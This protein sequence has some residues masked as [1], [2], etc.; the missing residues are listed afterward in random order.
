[1][2]ASENKTKILIVEH[3]QDDIALLLH[4]LKKAHFNFEWE[5]AADE[6]SYVMALKNFEPELI[7]SDYTMPGF[8]GVAAFEIKQK[9]AIM[10]PFIIVSGTIG[11]EE[12]VELIKTGI[13]DY[14][15]KDKLFTV[16]PKIKRAL[17]AMREEEVIHRTKNELLHTET[18]L[19]ESKEI[20]HDE[21]K[22][23]TDKLLL[24]TASAG[25]G[26]WDWDIEKDILLWD[27]GMHRLYDINEF[28][29]GSIYK[30]WIS[31]LHP[32]DLVR[33][34][35]DIQMAITGK[36]DYD[37]EFRIVMNDLSIRYIRATGIIEKDKGGKIIRLVGL[38]WD[39]SEEKETFEKLRKANRMY[40]FISQINQTITH[41]TNQ[42][43]LFPEIC[44]IALN[45]G[46]F[47]M[48]WIG[49]IDIY[50]N[51][52]NVVNHCGISEKDVEKFINAPY[53]IGGP[54]TI[55]L[56]TGKY[57]VCNEIVNDFHLKTWREFMLQRGIN[58]IIVLPI[59]KGGK[60]IGTF[61]LYATEVHFFDEPEIKLLL[62]ATGDISFA[63]D[64]FEKEEHKKR[65]EKKIERSELRMRIAQEIAH[66]GSWEM[67]LASGVAIWSD[68][69]CRIY[70]YSIED[71][72][73]TFEEWIGF[74]HPEDLE[75]V[76]EAI[77]KAQKT[78]S[79][80]SMDHR[81]V[82]KDKSIK[83]I[84]S[85]SKF[86]YDGDVPIILTAICYD[87]TE[88]K[89]AEEKLYQSEV[90]F[91][92][93]F[94]NSPVALSVFDLRTFK[95]IKN[96]IQ[97][98]RL[99]KYS[100][101][102]LQNMGPGDISP[103]YQPNGISSEELIKEVLAKTFRGE[104]PDFEWNF[105][106][107]DGNE[108]QCETRLVLLNTAGSPLVM[109]SSID[110][111][112]KKKIERAI[113]DNE[114]RLKKAEEIA[115][116][117]HWELDFITNDLM[118]SE[119]GC[120]I[121]GR[122]L[123]ENRLP[124][125]TWSKTVHPDDLERIL[126][127]IKKSQEF[128]NDS[129]F[130]HRILLDDGT[131]KYVRSESKFELDSSGKPLGMFGI[132]HDITEMTIAQN[133]LKL[134]NEELKKTNSELD[135]LVY[136][137]SHELRSPLT[138]MMGLFSLIE[139]KEMGNE[140]DE[141]LNLVK[142]SVFK[143]D[144][145]LKEMLDYSRNTRIPVKYEQVEMRG[146]IETAFEDNIYFDNNFSFDKQIKIKGGETFYSDAGRIKVIINN[147]ISNSLKY[148]KKDDA[149]S[150]IKVSCVINKS[151][152]ILQVEDNGIGIKKENIKGIFGMFYRA[153]I[154]ASGSG[155]GLYI[156]KECAEKLGGNIAVESEFG[157]G[158]KFIVELPNIK[159]IEK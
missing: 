12:A 89:M 67:D 149:S 104:I 122:E 130:Y 41:I 44:K 114:L 15:L 36:K 102:E 64:I 103:M 112:E 62:E 145:T 74:I 55:V 91:R 58:S 24:A 85:E 61:N 68:E 56:E 124:Y 148:G 138:A 140:N 159:P 82:L 7:L 53:A 11:E 29:F 106:D 31:R 110:L 75:M 30:G 26:I 126:Y 45:F 42:D 48:A 70:G 119:E 154:V 123:H 57:Y 4:E 47:K 80:N 131:I 6:K 88:S 144:E 81:I 136:S 9:M 113:K 95:F 65:I 59:K 132:T 147:L 141:L 8:G 40:A 49:M 27:D 23:L 25:M 158:T 111:T 22:A 21:M 100:D 97:A 63:L 157:K 39:I 72:I 155:L 133:E 1:M 3:D 121:F 98:T 43:E 79:D 66:L 134:N 116:L 152:M 16:I 101:E 17:T 52:I 118:L 93:F 18:L 150:F 28:E 105:M 77:N 76:M 125:E 117:G 54:Q 108:V 50:E 94:N 19:K 46:K 10:I 137:I 151:K 33:V 20:A 78:L 135:R 34:N 115:H 143:M 13:T 128:M 96:N 156:T 86:E 83:Y 146:V 38:N 51:K 5:I 153:T 120:R 92:E 139:H 107:R 73:H 84:H 129:S 69:A 60:I 90:Q 14:A 127:E 87:K 37:T 2:L 35:E 99:Y 142:K 32:E 71:N 109:A